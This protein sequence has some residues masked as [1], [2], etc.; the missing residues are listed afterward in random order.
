MGILATSAII[1][2]G[3]VLLVHSG[4]YVKLLGSKPR[5]G[6]ARV[7]IEEAQRERARRADHERS[8][9]AGKRNFVGSLCKSVL[10][11][12]TGRRE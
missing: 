5:S 8:R 6:E 1:A 9:S 2:L 7:M 3:A 12:L 4:A 11:I 10:R